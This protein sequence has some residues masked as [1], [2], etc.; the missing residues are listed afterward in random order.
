MILKF[1]HI[2]IDFCL[3]GLLHRAGMSSNSLCRMHPSLA[4]TLVGASCVP[5]KGRDPCHHVPT[6]VGTCPNN[7]RHAPNTPHPPLTCSGYTRLTR[8]CKYPLRANETC[9]SRSDRA[10]GGGVLGERP[11]GC[12][13]HGGTTR[14][15]ETKRVPAGVSLKCG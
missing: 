12:A 6:R 4:P 15:S 1:T 11:K 7:N 13:D 14:R 5:T 3:E 2:F 9:T 10:E 8:F